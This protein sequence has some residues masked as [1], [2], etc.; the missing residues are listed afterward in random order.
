MEGVF[1]YSLSNRV[2]QREML[3]HKETHAGRQNLKKKTHDIHHGWNSHNVVFAL[4]SFSGIKDKILQRKK[5]KRILEQTLNDS[6]C[7][8]FGGCWRKQMSDPM[9]PVLGMREHGSTKNNPRSNLF[10]FCFLHQ[11]QTSKTETRKSPMSLQFC[12]LSQQAL[13]ADFL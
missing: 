4:D 9:L 7:Y 12:Y 2:V 3:L 8:C 5:Y 6:F 11:K 10:C 1:V 13:R